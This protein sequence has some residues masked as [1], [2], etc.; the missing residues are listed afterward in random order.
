M[1]DEILVLVKANSD[2][3]HTMA[4]ISKEDWKEDIGV[5]DGYRKRLKMSIKI[6]VNSGMLLVQGP[7]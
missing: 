5:A 7:T 1:L 3:V 2:N 4:N 6:W